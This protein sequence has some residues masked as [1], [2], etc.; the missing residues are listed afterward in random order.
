MAAEPEKIKVGPLTFAKMLQLSRRY[1]CP[2]C[3]GRRVPCEKCDGTRVDPKYVKW[4][5]TE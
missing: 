2:V 3:E 5:D 1:P 4:D